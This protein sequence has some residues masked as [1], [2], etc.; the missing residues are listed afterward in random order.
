MLQQ[1]HIKTALVAKIWGLAVVFA[2]ERVMAR[3]GR[4]GWVKMGGAR[5]G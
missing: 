3:A 1:I 4:P 2:V 5:L